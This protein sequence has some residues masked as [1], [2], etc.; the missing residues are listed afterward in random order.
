MEEQ[1]KVKAD[2]I[3]FH[4][5]K[6]SKKFSIGFSK[7]ADSNT[8]LMSYSIALRKDGVDVDRFSRKI[9]REKVGDRLNMLKSIVNTGKVHFTDL[10]NSLT[11][12]Y[13]PYVVTARYKRYLFRAAK[14]FKVDK[15]ELIFKSDKRTNKVVKVAVRVAND[16]VV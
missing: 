7:K 16:I 2:T 6:K 1:E 14:Y 10:G 8:I 11:T 4:D 15:F 9:G 13:L 12:P 3:L 5:S